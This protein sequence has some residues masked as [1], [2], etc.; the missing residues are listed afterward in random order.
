M[1]AM[2]TL[3][4]TVMFV[5]C[6]C[7]NNLTTDYYDISL[8][9][10]PDGIYRDVGVFKVVMEGCVKSCSC[11]SNSGS[12]TSPVYPLD[13]TT[14]HS[15][16]LYETGC[17]GGNSD[18]VE[19]VVTTLLGSVTFS[20]PGGRLMQTADTI[21]TS[22]FFS[23]TFKPVPYKG[24]CNYGYRIVTKPIML[25]V[26]N[27]L[28]YSSLEETFITNVSIKTPSSWDCWR[29]AASVY[30]DAMVE[31]K[32]GAVVNATACDISAFTRLQC[33]LMQFNI[34]PGM[35]PLSPQAEVLAHIDVVPYVEAGSVEY[36]SLRN[37]KTFSVSQ[38]SFQFNFTDVDEFQCLEGNWAH[39]NDFTIYPSWT[40][41]KVGT[42][43]NYFNVSTTRVYSGESGGQPS[44][45]AWFMFCKCN[46]YKVAECGFSS[47]GGGRYY[48]CVN[49]QLGGKYY[50]QN[51][52][53]GTG[54]NVTIH[55]NK[56]Y[57]YS[58]YGY[59]GTGVF[60]NASDVVYRQNLGGGRLVQSINGGVSYA[61]VNITG[62]GSQIYKVSPCKTFT[63]NVLTFGTSVDGYFFRG[64][65]LTDNTFYTNCSSYTV[66]TVCTN[67]TASKFRTG[68]RSVDDCVNGIRLGNDLCFTPEKQVLDIKRFTS[69]YTEYSPMVFSDA[70]VKIPLTLKMATTTEFIPTEAERVSINCEQFVCSG[71]QRCLTL[72]A[73]Y[74]SACSNIIKSFSDMN[75]IEALDVSAFY[76]KIPQNNV[77]LSSIV[78]SESD[79]QLDS[80]MPNVSGGRSTIEDILFS[81]VQTVGLPTDEAYQKCLDGQEI[82]DIFCTQY[83]NGIAVLPPVI[84]PG[85]Q[86]GY[87]AGLIGAMAFGGLTSAAAIPFATQI[88]ARIN[89]LGITQTILLE[90]QKEIANK[91]NNALN[92]T[93]QGFQAV[94]SALSKVEDFVN[95]QA[96]VVNEAFKAIGSNFGAIS[97]AINDIYDRLDQIKADQQADR[98]ITGRLA[99]LVTLVSAK[100]LQ[101]LEVKQNR[102]RATEK[103]AECVMSQSSRYGFCGNG[104]HIMTI[105]Q[106]APNGMLFLHV[107][108]IPDTFV[109][110]N[111]TPGFCVNSTY[112]LAPRTGA[113]IFFKTD[114]FSG[115]FINGYAITSRTLYQPR[116]I[117][118]ADL[119]NLTTCNVT[120]I[121]ITSDLIAVPSFPDF[122]FTDDF[123]KWWNETRPEF[124]NI[125]FNFTIP[126]LNITNELD[127]INDVISGLNDSYIELKDLGILTTYIKWPWYVWLLIAFATIVFI[128]ILAWIFFMTGCCGCCC[129]CF[130]I[131][132][133]MSKCSKRSSYYTTFDDDVLGEQIRPKKSV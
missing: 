67:S 120:F 2:L 101:L 26:D 32:N 60:T 61:R 79:L 15:F 23:G 36:I 90:N 117:E 18:P 34:T 51:V 97:N 27:T 131:I 105:P 38:P 94:G 85:L 74:G 107:S 8:D 126:Y 25:F 89:H 76:A 63:T 37:N 104:S 19:L 35:Y 128:L 123:D 69:N 98:L 55:F 54:N 41:L 86:A 4:M 75:D 10:R 64:V 113:G 3:L 13:N 39:G 110:V 20:R 83:Y 112:A 56:C 103:I 50:Y 109:S 100:Q 68:L 6:D 11:N 16:L 21:V 1:S 5:V 77:N 114:E 59:N 125:D 73:Q 52:V 115:S 130:G 22:P 44:C 119:V 42:G 124:P 87:T 17:F 102:I 129:G 40:S 30:S 33:S 57:S 66:G 48:V 116:A 28:V 80:I 93:I 78:T 132:P 92:Y 46:Q 82:R 12:G 99:A 65:N 7:Q 118:V 72:L 49:Y 122:N 45:N 106:A 31:Y 70:V 81:K 71:S 43:F 47:S 127:R 84:S 96:Y 62:K 24:G 53:A 91:F 108:Y 121:N 133:L 95:Q 9:R 88:Q 14:I 58:I 29:Y 111:A